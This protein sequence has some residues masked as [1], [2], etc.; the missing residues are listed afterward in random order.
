MAARVRRPRPPPP[1]RAFT[2]RRGAAS[3]ERQ[4]FNCSGLTPEQLHTQVLTVPRAGPRY[5]RT[6]ASLKAA[7]VPYTLFN[8]TDGAQVYNK[9]CLNPST[10]GRPRCVC[11]CVC[12]C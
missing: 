10:A 5:A 3:D 9:Y 8:G 12:V 11:V 1:P 7:R 6:V 2:D 4:R